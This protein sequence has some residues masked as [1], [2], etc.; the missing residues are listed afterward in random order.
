MADG[1]LA[2]P[3]HSR[4]SLLIHLQTERLILREFL[5]EDL[6]DLMALDNDPEVMLHINEGRPRS[7]EEVQAFLVHCRAS[8]SANP[9]FGYWAALE[10]PTREFI[11]WFH[12]RPD[13]VFPAEM[14]VGYRLKRTAWGRGIATEGSIALIQKGF[15]EQG[16]KSVTGRTMKQNLG[17]SNVLRK[18]GLEFIDNYWE[19][20]FPG[21]DKTALLFR[22]KLTN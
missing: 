18:A 1:G 10:L 20:R 12:F 19:E 11:G 4:G 5:D 13:R 15:T 8:C 7:R 9:G 14:E 16:V 17:S 2:G 3:T 6:D 22:R 21:E